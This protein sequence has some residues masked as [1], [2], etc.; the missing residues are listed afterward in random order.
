MFFVSAFYILFPLATMN[1]DPAPHTPHAFKRAQEKDR[2]PT[3]L[4]PG[5]SQ[6]GGIG[7]NSE[8]P[9]DQR[10]PALRPTDLPHGVGG[11]RM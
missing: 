7:A 6:A 4:G 9:K 3:S 11:F 10:T 2:D 5:S 8:G 1:E